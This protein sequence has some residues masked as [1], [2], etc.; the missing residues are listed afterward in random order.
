[1]TEVLTKCPTPSL[2]LVSFFNFFKKS[3]GTATTL[4][5]YI[6]SLYSVDFRVK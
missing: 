5:P 3:I 6:V 1:M 2:A 4:A